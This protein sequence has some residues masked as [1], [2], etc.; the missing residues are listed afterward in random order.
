MLG[1][2][3]CCRTLS[4]GTASSLE[5]VA[6]QFKMLPM[7]LLHNWSNKK[8]ATCHGFYGFQLQKLRTPASIKP[9]VLDFQDYR[10]WTRSK[11]SNWWPLAFSGRNVGQYRLHPQC[12]V[13]GSNRVRVKNTLNLL[14]SALNWDTSPNKWAQKVIGSPLLEI[15]SLYWFA[16][17]GGWCQQYC[18]PLPIIWLYD[19][20]YISQ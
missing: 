13:G 1:R 17:A 20:Q 16:L 11:G 4:S 8:T 14:P 2:T 9:E 5:A 18:R 3:F 15:L 7:L 19:P 12:L 6:A 10:N